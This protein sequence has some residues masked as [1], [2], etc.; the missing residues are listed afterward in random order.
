MHDPFIALA[1]DF[2]GVAHAHYFTISLE[3]DLMT[4]GIILAADVAPGGMWK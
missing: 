1:V 4:Q 3:Y 2:R